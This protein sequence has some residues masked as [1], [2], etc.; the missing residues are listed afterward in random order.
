MKRL[1]LIV[2]ILVLFSG[3][4]LADTV[5]GTTL[6]AVQEGEWSGQPDLNTLLTSQQ[7]A[8]YSGQPVAPASMVA[9]QGSWLM[10]FNVTTSTLVSEEE[11]N[12]T[13]G[14]R[15]T[16]VN[17]VTN[18]TSITLEFNV[19]HPPAYYNVFVMDERGVVRHYKVLLNG[20]STTYTV[21]LNG[22]YPFLFVAV[23]GEG[24]S[25]AGSLDF[26]VL[27]DTAVTGGNL[28]PFKV[29]SVGDYDVYVV[30]GYAISP[31]N[32]TNTDTV[33]YIIANRKLVRFIVE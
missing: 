6:V 28:I 25:F 10:A 22:V 8:E 24:I 7:D 16:D 27:F 4:V 32:V 20:N 31:I 23:T 5:V 29:S 19:N 15:I 13:V 18:K 12:M 11:A 1:L 33:Y 3:S 9:N 30:G 17:E 2:A 21:T 26:S 14:L